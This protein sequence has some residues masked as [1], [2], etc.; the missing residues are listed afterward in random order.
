[1][2]NIC[3]TYNVIEVSDNVP[4]LN[5][6]VRLGYGLNMFLY[7]IHSEIKFVHHQFL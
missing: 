7:Q 1:M 5:I 4:Y 3:N 6:V 2:V